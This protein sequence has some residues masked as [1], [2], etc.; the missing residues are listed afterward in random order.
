VDLPT[1]FDVSP[2]AC[3]Q[4]CREFIAGQFPCEQALGQP[5]SVSI[6]VVYLA[7]LAVSVQKVLDGW[8]FHLDP[9]TSSQR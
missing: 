8:L 4:R 2:E 9:P 3:V 7:G 1:D 5:Q 6:D